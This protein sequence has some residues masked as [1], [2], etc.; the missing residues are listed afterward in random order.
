[1]D[2]EYKK[3]VVWLRIQYGPFRLCIYIMTCRAMTAHTH[4]ALLVGGP[5]MEALYVEEGYFQ[6]NNNNIQFS[7]RR[8]T[9][10]KLKCGIPHFVYF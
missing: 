10:L 7:S 3:L 8:D 4:I 1:M 9:V 6:I 5:I 2:F